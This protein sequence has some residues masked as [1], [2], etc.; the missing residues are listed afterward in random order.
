MSGRKKA[1]ITGITGQDGSYL[2]ELLLNKGYEVHAIKRRSSSFNT[3]RIDHLFGDKNLHLHYGDLSDS[4]SITNVLQIHKPDEIYNMAAMSHVRTSFEI[5]EYTGDIT[6]LGTIRLLQ[7]VH[8]L[9]IEKDVRF[10]QA[11]SSEMYG[12]VQ[13]TPQTEKTP[14]YPCS[15][16]ACAKAYAHWTTINHREMYGMHASCGILFNHESPRR[17]ETFV[18]RKVVRGAVR[19]AAGEQDK[20]YLGNLN[21]ERD[22]GHAR[23]Y[24]EAVWLMMQQEEPDDYVIATGKFHSVRE[25][26]EYAFSRLGME[27]EWRGE[28]TEEQGIDKKTGR[29][30]I[31]IKS[32]YYR[33]VEV[34]FLQGDASKAKEKLAWQ[35]RCGFYQL[36]DEMIDSEK[37]EL[38]L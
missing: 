34:D 3:Q 18:T 36:I 5:P 27:L 11:S 2:A 21:A 9:H 13:E 1:F 6:G 33:P 17:G 24:M 4:S 7:C 14:F 32:V 25:L 19:I 30:L 12:R 20:L 16:Y 10:Y 28:G 38:G 29:Q 23:D 22:W 31:G 15:P 26:C 35:P 37:K 8:L